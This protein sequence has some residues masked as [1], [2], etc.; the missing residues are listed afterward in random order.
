MKSLRSLALLP[1][2]AFPLPMALAQ[3]P[4]HPDLVYATVGQADLHLDLY[5][6]P[7]PAGPKPL[8]IFIHGGGWSGGTNASLSGPSTIALNQGF[9]VASIEY[10]LTS[11][12]A[13]F[14]PEP[15][16][17]P[18][19]IHDVKAAV[20]FLR[21]N[22]GVYGLDPTRFASYGTSA[23]GHL[24]A[25]LAV[26]TGVAELEGTVGPHVGVSSAVQAGIDFF[27][28]TD[29]LRMGLDAQL[30]P[31]SFIDHDAPTSPESRLLGWDGPGQG[32]GDIRA[33]QSNPA[34][35]YPE[36]VELA[37]WVNPVTWVDP[38]DPP[39][40]IAHGT[41]DTSVPPTQSIRLS[42]ALL[43]AGVPHDFRTIPGAGHGLGGAVNQAAFT[44]I[45]RKLIGPNLPDVGTTVCTGDG[46]SGA[47]PC[48][49]E[50]FPGG[51]AGCAHSLFVGAGLTAS[52]AA[53]VSNDTLQLQGDSMPETFVLYF[54][55]T[56]L[57]NPGV[58]LAEGLLC[59]GGTITRLGVRP[60]L[61]GSALYPGPGH[62][63]ISVS[64]GVTA[65]VTL[66]YQGWYRDVD[67]HCNGSNANLT[68]AIAVTWLP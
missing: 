22:A 47:C 43:A 10:R 17:F 40:F 62:P 11:Q 18:A 49:N 51:G 37:T 9:A 68:N 16:T 4:T 46:S 63:S 44:F 29:L 26:S 19:Q 57:Q 38:S 25:L 53:S 67:P 24:S 7:A 58:G 23:G 60:T 21:A 30:P 59:A 3:G 2:L 56:A 54:Q 66:Y 48:G 28:P 36:L 8:L 6:P 5:I 41:N 33:N 52:G 1:A 45:R 64:G 61:Q 39:L 12:A 32:V 14:A 13:L 65:G 31:G 27:G 55:G 20:R 34:P 35:P 15:V 42:A 50:S